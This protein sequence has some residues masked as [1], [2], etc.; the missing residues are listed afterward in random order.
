M[1]EGSVEVAE[2]VEVYDVP[3]A[4]ADLEEPRGEE[5]HQEHCHDYC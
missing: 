5:E 3:V 4:L 2:A 1:I